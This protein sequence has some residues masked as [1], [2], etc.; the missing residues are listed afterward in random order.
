VA[1]DVPSSL[2]A[3]ILEVVAEHDVR[4]RASAARAERL[5]SDRLI[6]GVPDSE[7]SGRAKTV[8]EAVVKQSGGCRED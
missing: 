5:R 8:G 7:E 2:E 1:A 4:I 3:V 6:N